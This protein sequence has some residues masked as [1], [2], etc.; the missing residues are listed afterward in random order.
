MNQRTLIAQAS[1]ERLRCTDRAMEL[2][3]NDG[4]A[5]RTYSPHM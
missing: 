5:L 3:C 4:N 1:Y 2:R